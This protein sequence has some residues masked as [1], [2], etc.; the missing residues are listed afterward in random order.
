VRDTGIGISAKNREKLF[1]KFYRVKSDETEGITGTGLGL[2]ITEELVRQMKGTISVE[3]IEGV[4]T[5][6]IIAFP[7]APKP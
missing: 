3:S 5:H 7:I 4:G 2:W 1:E 6:F